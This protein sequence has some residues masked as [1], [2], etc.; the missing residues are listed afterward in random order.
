MNYIYIQNCPGF[1]SQNSFRTNE[2]SNYFFSLKWTNCTE[3]KYTQVY[4]VSLVLSHTPENE[5]T[6]GNFQTLER[7]LGKE[8][9]WMLLGKDMDLVP[10]TSTEQFTIVYST[11]FRDLTQYFSFYSHPYT[12]IHPHTETHICTDT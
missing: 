2:I 5:Y 7:W 10:S 1:Y 12:Q 4:F 6:K 11:H 3:K 9:I 8:K